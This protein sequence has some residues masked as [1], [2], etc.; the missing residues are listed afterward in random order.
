MLG[1]SRTYSNLQLYF[2]HVLDTLGA[3]KPE[4]NNEPLTIEDL[5][6]MINEHMVTKQEF[7]DFRDNVNDRFDRVERKLDQVIGTFYKEFDD[8]AKRVK[9]LEK[10]VYNQ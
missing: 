9:K 5:A 2:P 8:L 3:M 10:A 1:N 7:I 6:R 4:H